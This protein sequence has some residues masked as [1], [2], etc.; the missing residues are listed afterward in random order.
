MNKGEKKGLVEDLK[1]RFKD[2]EWLYLV[3][4]TS[5]NAGDMDLLRTKARNGS[6]CVQIV[7]NRLLNLG[8]EGSKFGEL[9]RF[10]KGRTGVL[11]GADPIEGAKI[12]ADFKGKKIGL[13]IKGGFIEGKIYSGEEIEKIARIPSREELLAKTVSVLNSPVQNLVSLL[14]NIIGR[15]INVISKIKTQNARGENG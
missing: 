1:E 14:G 3:D 10:L 11:L 12:L 8:L 5:L 15:F 2:K 13:K 6:L 4:F 9:Q 7:K